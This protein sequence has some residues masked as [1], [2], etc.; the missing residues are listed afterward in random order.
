MHCYIPS[1]STIWRLSSFVTVN[2]GGFHCT[3]Q[4]QITALWSKTVGGNGNYYEGVILS[5]DNSTSTITMIWSDT[6][7]ILAVDIPFS[8]VRDKSGA[9]CQPVSADCMSCP[10]TACTTGNCGSEWCKG[11][12]VWDASIDTCASPST[13]M[14]L[15][16]PYCAFDGNTLGFNAGISTGVSKWMHLLPLS[17]C[18][19]GAREL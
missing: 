1:N 16:P 2:C 15:K 10:S 14:S 4:E 7:N 6:G 9:A 19:G 12:C 5:I 13:S 8:W 17:T 11:D 18:G 3:V